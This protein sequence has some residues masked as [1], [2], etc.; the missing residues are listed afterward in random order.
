[1]KIKVLARTEESS[2]RGTAREKHRVHKNPD[3]LLHP[4]E[5]AREYTRAVVAAKM[6]RMFAKP[7]LG[8]MDDHSDAVHCSSTSPSSLSSF[9]S[10][11]ADG[12]VIVWDVPT[13][14]KLWSVYAHTGF[15]K[16]VA[17]TRDGGGFLSVGM[18]KTIK[19]WRLSATEALASG[20][21]GGKGSSRQA[22]SSPS[23]VA[24]LRVWSG[25]QSYFSVDAHWKE[26]G[27]FAT[28]SSVVELWDASRGDPFA[29]YEWGNDSITSVRWNPAETSLLA[30]TSADRGVSLFDARQS[31]PLR[32]ATLSMNCN[33]VAWNPREPMNFTAASED[34]NCYTFD[35][36][37]LESALC[38]HKGHVGAVM[39]VHYAP[40]GREFVTGSYDKTVRIWPSVG[41]AMAAGGGAG[42]FANV[43]QGRSRE[44][45][46]TS[47]MQRV[48][49]VRFTP[50]ARFILTCSDDTNVRVWKAR[51][52]ESLARALPRERAAADYR[53]A[54]GK[55]FGHMPEVKK[56]TS[57]RPVPKFITSLTTKSSAE[58]SKARRKL[59]NIRAHSKPGAV[60]GIAASE[61]KKAILKVQ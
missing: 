12:E 29:T 42:S 1:M 50:D 28:S 44:I 16:G 49:S 17:V 10:G 21:V 47:R 34:S 58:E 41:T 19:L 20:F 32:K 52:S 55:R 26:S 35:M 38:V 3:P 56:I 60:E 18:D 51:A 2:T 45:Y 27:R 23:A 13:R 46:H 11:A 48:F 24:P 8:A 25:K 9:V 59:A 5:R 36:R 54:L 39:D 4:F 53:A 14:Q 22:T 31:S 15:V 61:K 57:Q 30:A 6:D 37:K 33:A 43:P 40:T 7:F